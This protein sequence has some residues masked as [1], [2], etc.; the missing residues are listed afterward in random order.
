MVFAGERKSKREREREI[1]INMH[2][3]KKG[4]MKHL[5]MFFFDK[6]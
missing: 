6:I 4:G 3:T 2:E 5:Q 1:Q